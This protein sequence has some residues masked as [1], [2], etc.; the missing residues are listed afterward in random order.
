MMMPPLLS[1]ALT[2][3]LTD[4]DSFDADLAAASALDLGPQ[5]ASRGRWGAN[6]SGSMSKVD[7]LR[8][9]A[10]ACEAADRRENRSI[11]A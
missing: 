3:I 10:Q 2:S 11:C 9:R 5:K 8:L 7:V 6:S 1:S 4:L